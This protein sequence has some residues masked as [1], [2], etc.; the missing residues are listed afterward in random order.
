MDIISMSAGATFTC[1]IGDGGQT[2]CW[3]DGNFGQTGSEGAQNSDI[4]QEILNFIPE[5]KYLSS[6]WF[7]TCALTN[8]GGISCWGK[9]YEGELGNSSTVSRAEA[10]NVA[11]FTG[12]KITRLMSIG[13][14]TSCAVTT[15]NELYCWGKNDHGQVGNGTTRDQLFPFLIDTSIDEVVSLSV[16]AS[17]ACYLT[18]MNAL[19]CWGANDHLQLGVNNPE[20]STIPIQIDIPYD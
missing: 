14:R 12:K 6:G 18:D 3:G 5:A 4:P 20:N 11:E 13:G 7:H 15:E 19:W 2:W 1:A 17:H 9:N 16:G 10:V 8:S